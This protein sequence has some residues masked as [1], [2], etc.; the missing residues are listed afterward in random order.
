MA[1]PINTK[2]IEAVLANPPSDMP[3]DLTLEFL[4]ESRDRGAII[5]ILVITSFVM[6]VVALRSYAR[7]VSVRGFGLDDWLALLALVSLVDCATSYTF[8]KPK[9][10]TS[11][12]LLSFPLPC[13]LLYS[14]I[15]DQVGTLLISN[16]FWTM[17][18]SAGPKPW[19]SG[20]T[21]STRLVY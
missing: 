12:R 21:W 4:Q 6:I 20:L 19:T 8:L 1:S 2:G 3:S 17:P 11:C 7:Y 14:S 16:M 13:F 10:T 9:L 5:A 18:S 15:W